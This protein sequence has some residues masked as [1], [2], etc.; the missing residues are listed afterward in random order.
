[1]YRPRTAVSVVVYPHDPR[2]GAPLDLS[3]WLVAIELNKTLHGPVGNATL[4]F[5]LPRHLW[6]GLELLGEDDWVLVNRR[7]L[8]GTRPSLLFVDNAQF[9]VNTMQH[10][11]VLVREFTLVCSDV[12]KPF[13]THEFAFMLGLPIPVPGVIAASPLVALLGLAGNT[14]TPGERLR[15][16]FRMAFRPELVRKTVR[17]AS[18]P[19]PAPLPA[20]AVKKKT[21]QFPPDEVLSPNFRL[22]EFTRTMY[23]KKELADGDTVTITPSQRENLRLLAGQLEALRTDLGAPIVVSSGLRTPAKNTQNNGATESLHLVGK[24]ADI[25]VPGMDPVD[26]ALAIRA[27]IEA[28]RMH[29]GG[30]FLYREFVHYDIGTGGVKRNGPKGEADAPTQAQIGKFPTPWKPSWATG[31]AGPALTATQTEVPEPIVEDPVESSETLAPARPEAPPAVDVEYLAA[32]SGDGA[33]M[34]PTSLASTVL[35]AT[36]SGQPRWDWVDAVDA[37]SHNDWGRTVAGTWWQPLNLLNGGNTFDR[38]VRDQVDSDFNELFYD[39]RP[40]NPEVEGRWSVLEGMLG[41]WRPAIVFRRRPFDPEHWRK[42]PRVPVPPGLEQHTTLVRTGQERKTYFLA[43]GYAGQQQ[44]SSQSLDNT[45]GT[46]DGT[47]PALDLEGVRQ[48]GL[49]MLVAQTRFAWLEQ[50]EPLTRK[51]NHSLYGWHR[52]QPD[53]FTAEVQVPV[54]LK[55]A[56]VG[57]VLEFQHD[58]RAWHGYIETVRESVRWNEEGAPQAST[59]FSLSRV[60]PAGEYPF[61]TPQPWRL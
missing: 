22:R 54:L 19:S 34:A 25:K 4:R 51:A 42:L 50:L 1:V 21:S 36:R 6:R 17:E 44:L 59:Q 52:A 48:H 56:L 18:K 15:G 24:A 53:A 9:S 23:S 60:H 2:I 39:M 7:C 28:K 40:P 46:G 12:G 30:V 27:A 14:L 31:N 3:E 57:L 45:I 26:V 47:V 29:W 32:Q 49:R 16:L 61:P 20:P 11:G 10:N 41:G 13:V 43:T 35:E 8:D 55:A 38:C 33:Y 58:G 37:V 5:K